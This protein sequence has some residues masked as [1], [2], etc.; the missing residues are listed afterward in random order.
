MTA[1]AFC[2]NKYDCYER[3]YNNILIVQDVKVKDFIKPFAS[4]GIN[5]IYNEINISLLNETD[6]KGFSAIHHTLYNKKFTDLQKIS[7]IEDLIDHGADPFILTIHGKSAFICACELGYLDIVKIMCKH[8]NCNVNAT[9]LRGWPAIQFALEANK[10][11]VVEFLLSIGASITMSS[12]CGESMY[13]TIA[14]VGD[15]SI[16]STSTI[17]TYVSQM[18]DIKDNRGRTPLHIACTYGRLA[19]VK[20]LLEHGADAPI[21]DDY[22]ETST[23]KLIDWFNT[24]GSR[25]ASDEIFDRLQY[26]I[27]VDNIRQIQSIVNNKTT[28]NGDTE[29]HIA[30]RENNIEYITNNNSINDE[31][32]DALTPLLLAIKCNNVEAFRILLSACDDI[33]QTNSQGLTPLN[34]V[35]ATGNTGI[36]R[37]LLEQDNIDVNKSD[38]SGY[39]PLNNAARGQF[40]EIVMMLFKKGADINAKAKDGRT[41]YKNACLVQRLSISTMM[42]LLINGVK[43][44]DKEGKTGYKIFR[45]IFNAA[46]ALYE[47]SPDYLAKH[48]CQFMKESINIIDSIHNL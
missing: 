31:N 32:D 34:L 6:S 23:K 25:L 19:I 30:V 44:N 1:R 33:N 45:N 8:K 26:T 11:L 28:N 20:L 21:A 5:I 38:K 43:I 2:R 42:M 10:L 36:V 3:E 24:K 7:I 37:I 22:G 48:C 17:L 27:S 14:R 39:S 46:V 4:D 29:M 13:H 12:S 9:S 35:S 47:Q 18:K 41:V 15:D 40:D 16:R